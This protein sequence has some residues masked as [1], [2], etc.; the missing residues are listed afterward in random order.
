MMRFL[1]WI[2]VI[3]A[4]VWASALVIFVKSIPRTPVGDA[5]TTDAIVVLTGG[6]LRIAYGFELLEKGKAQ[7]LFISGV[8]K[9]S[10]LASVMEANHANAR[11]RKLADEGDVIVLGYQADSTRGNAVETAKWMQEEGLKSLRLVTSNYHVP[12]SVLEFRRAMPHIIMIADP[13]F[14]DQFTLDNWWEDAFSRGLLIKEFHKYVFA[15]FYS[16]A[17]D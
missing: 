13:V 1:L 8:D 4:L 6:S 17:E 12:R 3:A 14:P 5:V 10:D 15:L 11:I 16:L 7:T 9:E 2:V